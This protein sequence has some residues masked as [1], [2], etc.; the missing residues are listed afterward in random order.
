MIEIG[1]RPGFKMGI[2]SRSASSKPDEHPDGRLTLGRSMKLDK[3]FRHAI[4]DQVD[5]VI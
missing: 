1:T 4:V 5:L 3:E 2:Y